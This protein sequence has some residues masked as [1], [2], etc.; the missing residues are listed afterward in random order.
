MYTLYYR[1]SVPENQ[2]NSVI[3]FTI[4]LYKI[5]SPCPIGLPFASDFDIMEEMACDRAVVALR[6]DVAINVIKLLTLVGG[7]AHIDPC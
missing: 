6:A 5:S 4:L 2:P 3:I 1:T 7:D